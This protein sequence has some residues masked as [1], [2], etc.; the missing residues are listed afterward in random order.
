MSD[1]T[2]VGANHGVGPEFEKQ[3]IRKVSRRVIPLIF[4]GYMFAYFDR[5]NISFAALTM[6]E[7]LGMTAYTYGWV[8]GIFFVGYILFGVP[9][10][11]ILGRWGAKKWLSLLILSFGLISAATAAVTN[12]PQL[13]ACRFLLGMAEAG[14][15]PGI[16]VY[17]MQWYPPRYRGRI[18]TAF[19]IAIPLSAAIGGPL[20]GLM[21]GMDGLLGLD[22]W[23][24]LFLV[25]GVPAALIG[26]LGFKLITSTPQDASWLNEHERGWLINEVSGD[27][28]S[29]MAGSRDEIRPW[30]V[31][32][33]GKILTLAVVQTFAVMGFYGMS[34]WLPQLI[35]EF[36]ASSMLTAALAAVPFVV[37]IPA[38]I[39]IGRSSDKRGTRA[40]HV[41]FSYGLIAAGLVLTV[42]AGSS[43]WA[44]IGLTIVA[45]GNLGGQS[46]L[47]AIPR[48]ILT[49]STAAAAVAM[50][51]S[52]SNIGGVVGPYLVGALKESS[53][54]FAVPL[55]VL[56]GLSAV[57]SLVVGIA[58]RGWA[59][60]GSRSG[61]AREQELIDTGQAQGSNPR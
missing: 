7:D 17:V 25:E 14:V 20:A 37:A 36:T 51:S 39:L 32:L 16:I 46:S 53:G 45:V 49:A 56:A 54:G 13:V 28:D 38:M 21:L 1:A 52:V 57:A 15:F 27:R 4:I 47:F 22:G 42:M 44:L 18:L 9:S 26:I 29:A 5:S 2:F 61:N 40:A 34:L 8:A 60:Q 59:D 33:S 23:R 30:R 12:V 48:S 11:I 43:A 10:N 19:I 31:L 35:R 50:I 55:L 24:W 58:V 41:A 6:N 3:L